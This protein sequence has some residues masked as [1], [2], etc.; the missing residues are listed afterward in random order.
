MAM[1]IGS[2]YGGYA[3][4]LS[5]QT[6]SVNGTEKIQETKNTVSTKRTTE[7]Y[8]KSLK[9]RY[10]DVNITV[11]KGTNATGFMNYM[12]GAKGTSNI[13]IED[14]ILEKMASD[15]SYAA[16]YE[17][18]IGNVVKDGEECKK[19]IEGGGTSKLLAC[20]TRID[21]DGRVSYWSVSLNIGPK[22]RMGTEL[23]EKANAQLEKQRENKKKVKDQS[24]KITRKRRENRENMKN[25]QEKCIVQANSI[26]ELVAH[27]KKLDEGNPNLHLLDGGKNVDLRV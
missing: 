7:D 23:R 15:P 8:L 11:G 3:A 27:V 4:T 25:L 6:K 19:A 13:Y 20:G 22:V 17:K 9:D 18:V 2:A 1:E 14:N 21:K 16:K 24:E 12:L 10:P 26:K 5:N